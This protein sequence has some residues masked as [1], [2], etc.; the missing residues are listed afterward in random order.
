MIMKKLKQSVLQMAMVFGCL[1]NAFGQLQWSSYNNTGG[2]VSNNVASGGDATYGGSVTF[3][4]PQTTELVFMTKTF[5]PTNLAASGSSAKINFTFSASGGLYPAFTG[6]VFGMG[7]LNDPGTPGNGLDDTGYWTDLNT[8]NSPASFE[9]FDRPNTVTTF[10]QY[11]SSHKLGSGKVSLGYPTNNVSYGMQFQLNNQ[12]SPGM[13]IGTSSAYAS[14]GAVI[15]N[16][17]GGVGI[18]SYSSAVTL[19]TLPTTTFNEFA[20]MYNNLSSSPVTVTLSG[21]NLVPANPVVTAQPLGY[22]G[23]P[24]DN[25]P[26]TS[27]AVA[28]NATSG[29]PLS[30]QWYQAT[31]TATN[32]LTDGATGNGSTV[33]GS[34]TANLS[35]ANAQVADSANYFVVI[36]NAYG[37][38]TSA[39][40][41]LNIAASSVAPTITSISPAVATVI[42]GQGTNIT[43]MA[44]GSPAPVYYWSDN[45]GNL[46]QSGASPNLSLLN[47]QPANGGIYS[48]VASNVLGTATTNF[49]ISVI[50]APV[51]SSQPTN[52]LLNVGDAANFSVTASGVPAP[53]YQW[54]QNKDL[55]VGATATN[56]SIASAGEGDI[57]QYSVVVS[58]S[59]GVV[60]STPAVLAVYSS[61]SG[62]P[63]SPAN[64]A[65]E[66]CVDTLLAITF[67]QPP[68]VGTTG[69]VN[70]YDAA[71]PATP[72]DTLD[73]SGG[74]LQLRTVGGASLKTYNILINGNTAFLYPHSG[75]L[76]EGKTYFVTI[77]PGV[78]LDSG[79]AYFAG[80][81]G[82][83]GWQFSTKSTGPANA[84]NLVVAAD[85]SGDFCTVQGAIDFVPPANT[86]PTVINIKNGLYTEVD[87]VNG[88][89]NITFIGQNRAQT[90]ISYA[91]NNNLNP[92]STT[93]PM[94][95]VVSAND[96]AIENLTLTNSTPHGGSQAEALL[97][98]YAKRFI[99]LNATLCSYQDTLLVNQSGDQAYV[100][101]SHIQG[102]TDYIWGSGTL[103]ATNDE[104]MAMSVQ[105]YLTQARTAQNT[106][107]FAFV[108]CRIY[109][110]NSAIT[111]GSLGRD[112]GASGSTANYPY[113][114]VA[115]ITCTMDTNLIIP[116]GWVLGS[117][118]T[119]GSA[120]ANLRFWEYQSMDLNG[121]PVNTASRVAWST[122]L[123]GNTA[124]NL[125]ENVSN[126]LYGWQ[127]QLAPNILTNPVSLSV[128]GGGNDTM[129]PEASLSIH[130][131]NYQRLTQE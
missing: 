67:S 40:A 121:N 75:V 92:S 103:F 74:N 22:S 89:N 2:L 82:P 98:N 31:A 24:G 81:S 43:V 61:M 118:T 77:D 96:I 95:G 16:F 20:F 47:V 86:T 28:L 116:A 76:T 108:N 60:T 10:F 97:V 113:G 3:T 58:N 52:L 80:I 71:N 53:T 84:T 29:T 46:I 30:Y 55:L 110:A 11:D 15:T 9:L 56:Y 13:S 33:S 123:D 48:L 72:V 12:G 99:V 105:S 131:R 23:A 102:D 5:V 51:I 78:I 101:D 94:F 65:N 57:G 62:T 19:A 21:I 129:V 69:K 93:R 26:G 87:R 128:S 41:L 8:G 115:Y 126:W 68:S 124:T 14:A 91:N 17:S 49:T 73:L 32:A 104:L 63:S 54:Y 39:P 119:Q 79:G 83:T 100:Q 1:A 122:Q 18:Q 35:F 34:G 37:S 38:T 125:V 6:R 44:I 90:V 36:T 114:Q 42:S 130:K 64:N 25:T 50:V 4:I 70:I 107:G 117:G 111:N 7:L 127:P 109:G 45:N 85:G 88:K 66:I 106:N 120:T 27:F 59:A 112:A